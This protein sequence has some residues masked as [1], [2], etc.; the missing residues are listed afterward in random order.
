MDVRGPYNTAQARRRLLFATLA[1][2]STYAAYRTWQEKRRIRQGI[3]RTVAALQRCTET[4]V[5]RATACVVAGTIQGIAAVRPEAVEAAAPTESWQAMALEKL[6]GLLTTRAGMDLVSLAVA[7]GAQHSTAAILQH[8]SHQRYT[9]MSPPPPTSASAAASVA[10]SD[11][12]AQSVDGAAQHLATNRHFSTSQVPPDNPMLRQLLSWAAT[13]KGERCVVAVMAAAA[14]DSTR[15]YTDSLVGCNTYDDMFA[16]ASRP[17]HRKLL[18]EMTVTATR[19]A[20]VTYLYPPSQPNRRA[21]P[22][23]TSR[24]WADT[25]QTVGQ[26]AK[27]CIKQ[28]TS[29]SRY[30]ALA[31]PVLLC[32][33]SKGIAQGCKHALSR[34]R[35]GESTMERV[36]SSDLAIIALVL[37][38]GMAFVIICVTS[39]GARMQTLLLP[40]FKTSLV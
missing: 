8:M 1:A 23:T 37:V 25:V 30:A 19:E 34:A 24:S 3:E 12:R 32:A 7:V 5:T 22:E 18:Q 9:G 36:P 29:N 28:V 16:A 11:G 17:E 14:R 21:G 10:S 4:A 20:V 33:S 40:A 38:V 27:G 26:G 13:R 39:A 31:I 6:V 2:L 35:Y 15:A